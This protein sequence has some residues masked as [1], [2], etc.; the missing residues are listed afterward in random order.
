MYLITFGDDWT[1]G[2]GSWYKPG[3]PKIV[4]DNTD[5]NY[6]SS[7]RIMLRDYY[8]CQD[9]HRNFASYKSSNQKQ[10]AL[11]KNFF[12]SKKFRDLYSKD[13]IVLWGITTLQ[14]DFI[15][16]RSRLKMNSRLGL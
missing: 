13:M 9:R 3:M 2:T 15:I 11:A 8:G 10:F 12:I 14:R 4:Y 16:T 1:L 6:D 7:W 5:V